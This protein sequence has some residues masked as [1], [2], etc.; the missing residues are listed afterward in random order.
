MKPLINVLTKK[1][2]N[3]AS[4]FYRLVL[5]V[6]PHGCGKSALLQSF[7]NEEHQSVVNVG[8]E[9]SKRLME[10]PARNRPARVASLFRELIDT[11]ASTVL[12]DNI[13]VLF[14]PSLKMNPLKLLQQLSRQTT[15][16]A[17]W[18]GR[19]IGNTIT[20]AVEGESEFRSYPLSD[21]AYIQME[22]S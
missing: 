15:V 7:T 5:I 13:E 20:Y 19:I 17:T 2:H 12:L 1:A 16:V 11:T 3:A 6:G 9:L 8:V 10:E 22:E 21:I 14:E 4:A 18:P